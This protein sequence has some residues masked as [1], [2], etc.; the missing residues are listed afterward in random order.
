LSQFLR[1]EYLKN[2]TLSE[3]A[4]KEIDEELHS[5]QKKEN[6][7][8]DN[9][10]KHDNYLSLTCIIRF[11]NKGFR[12]YQIDDV[13]KYFRSAKDV[14]RIIFNLYSVNYL[15]SN[16]RS[17]KSILIY[18]DGKDASKCQITVDDDDKDWVDS[19]FLKLREIIS[20]YS[21]NN[22]RIR[23]AWTTFTIQ[24]I[25][26]IIGFLFSIWTAIK[27]SPSLPLKYADGFTFIIAFILFSNIWTYIYA[28]ILRAIDFL[29]PN[30]SFKKRE[31]IYSLIRAV[32]IAIFAS[33]TVFVLSWAGTTIYQF[34]I[35]LF[36]QQN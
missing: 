12:L 6:Q 26:V 13:L 29:W 30:I 35:S 4:L 16:S 5:L 18:F 23:N 9:D 17:G 32:L 24:I 7:K 25:G 3:E 8:I 36:I 27:F 33:T 31:G 28:F 11:D 10:G 34:I 2:L 14:E 19:N 22:H 20:R 21:N 15:I 1:D